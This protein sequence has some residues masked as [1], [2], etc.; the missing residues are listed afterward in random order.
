MATSSKAV[1]DE[2]AHVEA[3][4]NVQT[5]AQVAPQGFDPEGRDAEI[6]IDVSSTWMFSHPP[7]ACQIDADLKSLMR[8]S[9]TTVAPV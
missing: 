5:E 1:G 2:R 9:M 4:V 3:E 8:I 6:A 7:R